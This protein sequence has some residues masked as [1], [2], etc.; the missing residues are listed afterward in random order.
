MASNVLLKKSSHHELWSFVKD[1]LADSQFVKQ[2]V[3]GI[4]I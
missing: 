2:Y 3:N 1:M 4:G